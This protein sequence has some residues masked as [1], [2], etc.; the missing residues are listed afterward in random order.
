MAEIATPGKTAGPRV[1]QCGTGARQLP[2]LRPPRFQP[3]FR[4]AASQEQC[5]DSRFAQNYRS[6]VPPRL[7]RMLHR[8]IDFKRDSGHAARQA[9]G[10]ALRAARR[11]SALRNLRQAGTAGLLF[12]STTASRHVRRIARRRVAVAH[13]SR[14]A[15]AT[16]SRAPRRRSHAER[17]SSST[18][19]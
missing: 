6:C 15:D 3:P 16:L 8:S 7:R 4:Q 1:A 12:G 5:S 2:P 19:H 18:K 17:A 11:R 10:R 14:S 9:G 13:A